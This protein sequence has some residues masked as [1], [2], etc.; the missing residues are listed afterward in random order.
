MLAD[1]PTFLFADIVG[2]TALT[3]EHGDERAA[4][5]ALDFR[6][7]VRALLPRHRAEEVKGLGDAVMVR[8]DHP[9]LAIRLGVLIVRETGSRNGDPPVR[10]GMHTGPAVERDGDWYGA[11]VNLAARLCQA[12]RPGEVLVSDA[13]SAAGRRPRQVHLG[14]LRPY[15]LKNVNEP[16]LARR[17]QRC[18]EAA[19]AML[20]RFR[21]LLP[22]LGTGRTVR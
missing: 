17:A 4:D 8:V 12:A 20:E 2:F 22:A 18:G 11:A 5:V 9:D 14:E 16:L 7:R 6:R 15:A 21:V 10:V 3:V 13:T 1:H 19:R